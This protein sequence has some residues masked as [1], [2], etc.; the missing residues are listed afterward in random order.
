M[1][2]SDLYR[3]VKKFFEEQGYEVKGEVQDCD[4]LAV[5]GDEE[6]VVIE[7]KLSLN[8][9][10]I[11]QAV[12]RISLTSQVYI[13]VPAGIGVLKKRRRSVLKLLRMLGLGLLLLKPNSRNSPV[14][15]ALEPGSYKPRT[16]KARTKSAL[17]EFHKRDGDP[18]LGGMASGSG[19]VTSYRQGVLTIAQLLYE[20]G[21]MKVSQVKQ[22]LDNPK[23]GEILY[24][25]VYGWFNRASRGVYELS[26]KGKEEVPQWV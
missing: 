12:N 1:K 26:S 8:L 4:V 7:L 23:A 13:G 5:R 19:I 22:M 24:K 9:D 15:V 20:L 14:T 11:L 18:N 3:P 10:V 17:G 25:D 6:P 16:S 21:P 2:E